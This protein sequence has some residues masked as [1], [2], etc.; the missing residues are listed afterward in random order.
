MKSNIMVTTSW[1]DGHILDLKLAE[2]LARYNLPGTFYISPD[3]REFEPSQRMTS[4]Q[5]RSL[6]KTF[7]IGAH[8]LTHPRLPQVSDAE[9]AREIS[10]SKTVL[11]A[12]IGHPVTTFCYPGGAFTP[13]HAQ[14]ARAAG[15]TY[16]RTV[17]R[18]SFNIG[19]D[20]FAAPTT[21]H[22]YRHWS[23][24][25]RIARLARFSPIKTLAYIRNWDELAMALFDYVAQSGGVFHLW[26]HSWEIDANGDWNRLERV[27]RHISGQADIAY[28]T[29]GE[30]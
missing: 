30:L 3:D 7:E 10:G 28:V 12:I 23:D 21:V 14:M 17:E 8:T 11:E 13:A 2:L 1:D 18:F 25:L 22:A 27:L 15:Y 24:M 29:N 19:T 20:R 5:I 4:T 26:G 16:A 6:A 9:A